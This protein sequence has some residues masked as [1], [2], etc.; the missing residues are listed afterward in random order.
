MSKISI[1]CGSIIDTNK[2]HKY[3]ISDANLL[4]NSNKI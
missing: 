1:E 3:V 4:K 2:I